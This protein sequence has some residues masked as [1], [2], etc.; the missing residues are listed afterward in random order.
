MSYSLVPYLVDLPKLRSAVGSKDAALIAA[1]RRKSPQRFDADEYPLTLGQA[2]THLVMGEK[3]AKDDAHQYGYALEKLAAH[4]GKR[5]DFD[6]W[7][8]VRWEAMEDS[9]VA[10][11]M[12][13]GPPVKLPKI[14]GGFPVIGFLD[15]GEIAERVRR[16]GDEGLTHDDEELEELLKEFEAWLRT[17]AKAKQDLLLFYY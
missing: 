16:M 13:S 15:R 14:R 9:G 12:K 6:L 1:V 5:L 17:A 8:G 3:L 4:L 2:L 11:V 10:P 7:S